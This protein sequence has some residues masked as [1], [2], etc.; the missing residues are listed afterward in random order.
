MQSP[1]IRNSN[2]QAKVQIIC[3]NHVLHF[4]AYLAI[5]LLLSLPH[6]VAY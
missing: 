6:N 4:I 1:P 3:F 5:L 2:D